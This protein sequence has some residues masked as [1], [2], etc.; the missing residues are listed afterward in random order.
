[1]G[2]GSRWHVLGR[3]WEVRPHQARFAYFIDPLDF[4]YKTQIQRQDHW[5]FLDGD[6]RALSPHLK[7]PCE[8]KPYAPAWVA[9]PGHQPCMH[10]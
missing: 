3:W 8:V 9:G 1:M 10:C 6:R 7:P 5:E 4:T 2:Q